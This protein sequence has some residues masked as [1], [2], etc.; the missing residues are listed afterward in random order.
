MTPGQDMPEQRRG[1]WTFLTQQGRPGGR[2]ALAAAIPGTKSDEVISIL[3]SNEVSQS[4]AQSKGVYHCD[5]S[6]SMML[7]A[8]G[9]YNAHMAINDRFHVQHGSMMGPLTKSSI[10]IRR[11]LIARRGQPRQ[12]RGRPVTDANGGAIRQILARSKHTLMM[13]QNKWTDIQRHRVS[14]A[15]TNIIPTLR[16]LIAAWN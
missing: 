10:D 1:I 12:I 16:V 7:I 8:G 14:I 6:P 13:S 11:Q 2:A 4:Q 5:L 15:G 3:C 9:N